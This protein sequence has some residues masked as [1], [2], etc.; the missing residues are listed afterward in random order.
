MISGEESPDFT[1]QDAPRNAGS[2]SFKWGIWK[3]P[4]KADRPAQKW[5]RNPVLGL[6]CVRGKGERVV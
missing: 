2:S 4:Q 1:G 5:N 3:V 6:I